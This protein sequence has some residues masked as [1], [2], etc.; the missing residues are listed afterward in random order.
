MELPSICGAK[1]YFTGYV[2]YGDGTF[3][4]VNGIFG[5]NSALMAIDIGV[6]Y[7]PTLASISFGI[8]ALIATAILTQIL[9]AAILPWIDRLVFL[10]SVCPCHLP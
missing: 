4:V 9:G 3:K 5:F 7:V 6:F 10:H 1:P 8:I 2:L